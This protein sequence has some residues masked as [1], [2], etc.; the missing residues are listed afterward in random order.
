MTDPGQIEQVIMNLAVNAGDAM[1]EGGSL[2]IATS[3]AAAV[4]MDRHPEAT[5]G[6]YVALSVADSG[7]GMSEETLAHLFEPFFTTKAKGKGTGLGLSM[8]YG[9][10]RQCGGFIEVQSE[11]G[12]GT[13]FK[14]L[15]P[16]FSDLQQ[17]EEADREG[18]QPRAPSSAPTILLVEDDEIVRRMT[19][20][21]LRRSG[22]TVM[23]APSAAEALKQAGRKIDLLLTD[24]VLPDISGVELATKLKGEKPSLPVVYMSGYTDNL[25]IREVLSRPT[26]RFLQKPFTPHALLQKV[27]E[28]LG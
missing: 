14:I 26:A 12:A 6:L 28:T 15:L 22:Y 18:M 16:K 20:R 7:S 4:D 25:A 17:Q 10:V 23:E 19:G 27:R 24:I 21:V 11:A 13:V 2:T 3:G 8:V 1:P 5:P 9:I